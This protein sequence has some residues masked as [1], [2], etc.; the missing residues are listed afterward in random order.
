MNAINT[1]I[2]RHLTS[3]KENPIR[4]I[5]DP[6][7][8]AT[9]R[10]VFACNYQV[11]LQLGLHQRRMRAKGGQREWGRRRGC[12]AVSETRR[13]PP[14]KS[15]R[16]IIPHG[17]IRASL[18]AGLR[19]KPWSTCAAH[20]LRVHARHVCQRFHEHDDEHEHALWVSIIVA[21]ST[22][23]VQC[24]R[25]F[26]WFANSASMLQIYLY[27]KKYQTSMEPKFEA[28]L[29]ISFCKKIAH[30]LTQFRGELV[31]ICIELCLGWITEDTMIF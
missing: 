6:R 12:P 18:L 24:L 11:S 26:L 9:A 27:L 22:F 4:Q 17:G 8:S 30:I 10:S 31:E 3:R 21:H 5:R 20:A 1:F 19:A 7:T 2:L 14:R 13:G 15:Y 28:G 16:R 23:I 29:R 25:D